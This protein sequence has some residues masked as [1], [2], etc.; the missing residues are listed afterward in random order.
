ME[1]DG[2]VTDS[3]W[4]DYS[5]VTPSEEL[6]GRLID[7]LVRWRIVG[8]DVLRPDLPGNAPIESARLEFGGRTLKLSLYRLP[9]HADGLSAH[10][11]TYLRY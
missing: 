3:G 8:L 5:T 10:Y 9:P 4:V 6:T 1:V 7:V 2:G 11:F